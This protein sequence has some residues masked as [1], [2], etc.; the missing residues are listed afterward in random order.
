MGNYHPQET[1]LVLDA[2]RGEGSPH[3]DSKTNTMTI[4]FSSPSYQDYL[5]TRRWLNAVLNKK[6]LTFLKNEGLFNIY[7]T[8]EVAK[9]LWAGMG[10]LTN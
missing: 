7:A 8:E 2:S 3:V 1:A 6:P 5:E 10:L 9:D 4:I